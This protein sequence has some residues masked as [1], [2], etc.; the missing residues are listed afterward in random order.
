MTIFIFPNLFENHFFRFQLKA[1]R[2]TGGDDT[3]LD[4]IRLMCNHGNTV[5]EGIPANKN[6]T[7]DGSMVHLLYDSFGTWGDVF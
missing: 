4:S 1:Q 5:I 7:I 2:T 3:A 6:K